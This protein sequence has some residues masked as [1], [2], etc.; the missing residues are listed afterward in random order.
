M[1]LFLVSLWAMIIIE[2]RT[3]TPSSC[4]AVVKR[5][6]PEGAQ[7][8]YKPLP[9]EKWSEYSMLEWLLFI[10]GQFVSKTISGE[11]CWHFRPVAKIGPTPIGHFF[12]FHFR[13]MFIVIF[14]EIYYNA[15]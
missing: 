15:G 8:Y 2:E 10:V 1:P 12:W 7:I 9:P 14:K 11:I 3:F 13:E 4:V 6:Y 5:I